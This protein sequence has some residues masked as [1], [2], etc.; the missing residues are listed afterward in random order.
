MAQFQVGDT[1]Q[2]KRAPSFART[3]EFAPLGAIGCITDIE[4]EECTVEFESS[5]NGMIS[6]FRDEDLELVE[7]YRPE[8]GNLEREG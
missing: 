7:H 8:D 6:G 5:V 2:V 1:V 4:G 3:G